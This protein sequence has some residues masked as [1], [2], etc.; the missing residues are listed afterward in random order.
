MMPGTPGT[1]DYQQTSLAV[2]ND[3]A[4]VG[5][6][7]QVSSAFLTSAGGIPGLQVAANYRP[8]QIWQ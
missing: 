2:P 6:T 3:P 4:L 7:A 5:Q 8:I 1:R